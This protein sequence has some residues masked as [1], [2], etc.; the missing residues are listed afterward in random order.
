MPIDK[1]LIYPELKSELLKK[2]KKD[3]ADVTQE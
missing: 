2:R 1:K 3:Q